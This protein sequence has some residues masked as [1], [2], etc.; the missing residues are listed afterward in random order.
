MGLDPDLEQSHGISVPQ[1]RGNVREHGLRGG[2]E[3]RELVSR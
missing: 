3:G 2:N 1:G